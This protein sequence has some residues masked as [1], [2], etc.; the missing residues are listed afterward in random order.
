MKTSEKSKIKEKK[1]FFYKYKKY[2]TTLQFIY[3]LSLCCL[4][5]IGGTAREIEVESSALFNVF[6]LFSEKQNE[7]K[8]KR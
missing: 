7:S 6:D 5:C 1:S 8:F 4:G 2:Y 3:F